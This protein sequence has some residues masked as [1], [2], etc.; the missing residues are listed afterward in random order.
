MGDEVI[1]IK[2]REIIRTQRDGERDREIPEVDSKQQVEQV[3]EV[4]DTWERERPIKNGRNV[5]T[6]VDKKVRYEGG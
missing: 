2:Q 3:E 6:F 5:C 1:R 4:K